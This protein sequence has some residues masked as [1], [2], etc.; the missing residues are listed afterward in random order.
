MQFTLIR[1]DGLAVALRVKEGTAWTP[2]Q[3]VAEAR[4][5]VPR[6]AAVGVYVGN[7]RP[8]AFFVN[9]R[10]QFSRWRA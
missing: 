7:Q 4:R 10:G 5:L 8:Q 9:L 2:A 3:A 1:I 6:V